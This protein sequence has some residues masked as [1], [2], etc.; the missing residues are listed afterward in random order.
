LTLTSLVIKTCH[1]SGNPVISVP[2]EGLK[3]LFFCFSP[4]DIKINRGW[5][6][7]SDS[8]LEELR[9]FAEEVAVREGCVLYDL[10]FHDGP[11]RALRVYIDKPIGG[12]SID[13]CANVSKGLNLRL[14]VEDAI[15][16]GHY[17]LEVSSPGLDRKLTQLWHFEKAVGQNVRLKYWNAER[18]TQPYEGKLV[19]AEG[20]KLK[21]ENAKGPWELEFASVQKAQLK[22][23]DLLKKKQ[24]PGKKK[25]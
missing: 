19:A 16:G 2:E 22:T 20:T 18:V 9:K 13:D 3:A 7:L 10:E 23:A 4:V 6:L 15:P 5:V 17:D 1:R 14:D 21:F 8:Q 11:S 25:R 24:M 12:V